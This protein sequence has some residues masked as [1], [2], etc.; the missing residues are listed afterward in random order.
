MELA[1]ENRDMKKLSKAAALSMV[2]GLISLLASLQG[3]FLAAIA[4]SFGMVAI[5]TGFIGLY[6]TGKKST[7]RRGRSLGVAG[8]TLGT[9]GVALGLLA[10]A[11]IFLQQIRHQQ[12]QQQNWER[13]RHVHQSVTANR[14]PSTPATDFSSNLPIIVINTQGAFISKEQKTIVH[15]EVFGAADGRASVTAKPDYSGPGTLNLRGHTSLHLPKRSYTFHTTDDN[16]KQIR[17]PLLGLPASDDWI[18]YAAFEDKTMMRDV[19][20]FELTRRMGRYAPRTRFVELFLKD[21]DA[22]LS[23]RYYAGV[24]VLVEKIKRAPERVNIAKLTSSHR[25]EPEISGG[26]IFKRD[27][28]DNSD[29]RFHT[30]HGGPFFFVEPK[31]DSITTQQ[32]RWLTRYMNAFETAL[33]SEEF[34]DPKSG[35]AAFLDVDSFIDAHW[36]IEA[37][38]NVDGFR[39][40]CFLT[41]DRGGKLK[42][43]PPWDWNRAF[44]NANYYDGWQTQGWYWH[45]LRPNEISWYTRLQDDPQFLQR[46]NDRWRY[47]RQDVFN[48]PRIHQLID[49]L[50]D[51][52][53]EAQQRNFQRWPIL[54]Q[55]VTCNYYVGKTYRDEVTWL[56]KWI[57]NRV[58][59]I[60]RQ[61][62]PPP[63]L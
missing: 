43:E 6:V 42:L 13:S 49:Q 19:L 62:G 45:N 54:G 36:L 17:V 2:F 10:I 58:A 18:L 3:G 28:G 56:K 55:P 38:K 16:Q 44:G 33:H 32:K 9:V 24:Y 23:M 14:M 63:I 11:G 25:D 47:L 57:A 15:A 40:S 51:Q 4:V 59:W 22:P 29:D 1:R 60:D 21:S 41:K 46:C 35:Y 7:L 8:L 50:A 34:D 20:A 37:S 5:C 39:Y 53:D 30:T 61:V 52:L 31:A 12:V 27:H 48:V 26:Y